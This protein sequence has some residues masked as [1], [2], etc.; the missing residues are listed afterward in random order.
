MKKQIIFVVL[1]LSGLFATVP[2]MAADYVI[3]TKGAHAFV[4][5]RT[6]HLG[7]SWLY[8]RF[9]EF[10]GEFSYDAAKPEASKVSVLVKTNSLESNHAERDKH[11]RSS[12]F[13]DVSK[14]P[15]A[16]FVSTSFKPKGGDKFELKG[17][18]TLF[19]KTKE[20]TIDVL[21][22]GEGDDPWGG[23]RVG[24]EGTTTISPAD[25]G[26]DMSPM[27]E[28]VELTLSVEGIKK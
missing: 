9:T 18:M 28:T 19:G 12:D 7:I 8:G 10:G 13:L 11:L 16:K 4:Q 2:S 6:K 20:V 24:F 3:D 5:F 15:E 14:H 17:N 25:F 22:I 23:Y 1:T 27:V 21:K 26:I